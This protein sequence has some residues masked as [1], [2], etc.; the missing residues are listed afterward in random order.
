MDSHVSEANRARKLVWPDALNARDLG[1]LPIAGGKAQTKT[2]RRNCANH[3]QAD[4]CALFYCHT[5]KNRPGIIPASLLAI[6]GVDDDLIAEDYAL[7]DVCLAE[8]YL[9]DGGLKNESIE[10]IRARLIKL[11]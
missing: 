6:A 3:R 5:G 9:R 8:R 7:S 10:R 4:G 2:N 11:R 1:G